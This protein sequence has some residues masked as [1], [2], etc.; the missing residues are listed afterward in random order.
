MVGGGGGV[1]CN[2]VGADGEGLMIFLIRLY[3]GNLNKLKQ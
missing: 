2:A 3:L 1:S